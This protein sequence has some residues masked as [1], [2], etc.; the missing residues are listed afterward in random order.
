MR[1]AGIDLATEPGATAF[2]AI[3]WS[4]EKAVVTSLRV[5]IDDDFIVTV[6]SDFDKVGIDCPLGWPDDFARFIAAHH[7]CKDLP[8]TDLQGADWRRQLAYRATDR[9]VRANTGLVPLSVAADRIGLT[10]MRAAALLARLSESGHPV[11]RT[12]SGVVV[13]VYP[14]ASLAC[15]ELP[16]RGYKG[17]KNRAQ[18]VS[19]VQELGRAA[20]WLDLGG[21][22]KLC[23]SNDDAFDAVIAAITSRAAALGLTQTPRDRESLELAAAEGWIALPNA[24]LSALVDK[25]APTV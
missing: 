20:P 6:T 1:T 18:L 16:T 7:G 21:H 24:P 10:A 9:T 25:S 22:A 4:S 17:R 11:D 8:T 3:D 12:G 5:G 23:A 13:E 15:W 14:A 19:L 2:A